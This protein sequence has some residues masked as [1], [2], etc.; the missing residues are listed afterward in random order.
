MEWGVITNYWLSQLEDKNIT[1]RAEQVEG[2]GWGGGGYMFSKLPSVKTWHHR[3]TSVQH[4]CRPNTAFNIKT[5]RLN[6]K[7]SYRMRES[8]CDEVNSLLESLSQS[9]TTKKALNPS[10]QKK[11][12]SNNM[13]QI[14]AHANRNKRRVASHWLYSQSPME[15]WNL[16][17]SRDD[18]RWQ[19]PSRNTGWFILIRGAKKTGERGQKRT[20]WIRVEWSGFC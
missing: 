20:M 15:Q 1:N 6:M 8:F 17:G 11:G 7:R 4:H 10:T 5:T 13:T 2:G 9:Q 16:F 12:A 14:D 3:M 18:A 19:L